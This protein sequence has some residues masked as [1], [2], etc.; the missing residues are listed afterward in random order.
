VAT[1]ARA[2]GVNANL[3][4]HWRK[5]YHAGLLN[6]APGAAATGDVRLLP[7]VVHD[8]SGADEEDRPAQEEKATAPPVASMA[9]SSAAAVHI[10]FP[11]HV[12]VSVHGSADPAVVRTVLE[13][14]RG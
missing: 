8:E 9:T 12:F 14:L 6:P 2:H 1:V 11:G 13:S 7:V 10:E 4:F 3:V 5:L